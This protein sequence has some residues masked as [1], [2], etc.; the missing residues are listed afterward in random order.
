MTSHSNLSDQILDMYKEGDSHSRICLK[1]GISERNYSSILKKNFEKFDAFKEIRIMNQKKKRNSQKTHHDG[2]VIQ[3]TKLDKITP[4]ERIQI[5]ERQLA[6]QQKENDQLQRLLD[7]AK[8][9]MG[10]L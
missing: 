5:L 2:P 1:C 10:K 3:P 8:E 4:E 7:A 6:K 9:Y